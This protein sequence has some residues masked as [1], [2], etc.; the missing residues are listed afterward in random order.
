MQARRWPIPAA[1]SLLAVLACSSSPPEASAT[2][3]GRLARTTA[4]PERTDCDPT[5]VAACGDAIKSVQPSIERAASDCLASGICSGTQCL[6]KALLLAESTPEHAA[7]AAGYCARCAAGTAGCETGFYKKG[8]GAPGAVVLPYSPAIATRVLDTCTVDAGCDAT[9]HTCASGVL[10][11][12]LAPLGADAATCLKNAF[13]PDETKTTPGGPTVLSCTAKNCAGCCR[14]DQCQEGR[15][16]GACGAGGAQCETCSP[17]ESCRD[18]RCEKPCSPDTCIGCCD[19]TGKC[20]DGTTSATCGAGGISCKAC[21]SG[22]TCSSRQCIDV[23]CKTT[24]TTGCCSASGCQS[25]VTQ[26]ACGK[27]G[28]VCAVC[29]SGRTCKAGACAIDP[30]SLWDVIIVSA[31]LPPSTPGGNAWD[32]FGGLPDPFCKAFS[33]EGTSSH[34]GQTAT[35]NDTLTPFWGTKTL[36]SVRASELL[37]SFSVEVWDA[38]TA[39]NDHV[40]GCK[41]PLLP[42]VFDGL[43]MKTTCPATASGVSIK[44]SYRV[45]PRT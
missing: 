14:N 37:S 8:T 18:G 40:G 45:T 41:I 15:E 34:S 30:A 6:G 3:C 9:F 29:G 2:F 5:L 28:A 20:Q 16:G 38:D 32:G 44:I 25:G 33:S 17:G 19:G 43:L 23:S 10:A 31:E 42:S 13:R 36:I 27:G 21:T 11:E 39:F 7:L 1:F 24:C 22:F 12:A 26:A 4:C 35:E